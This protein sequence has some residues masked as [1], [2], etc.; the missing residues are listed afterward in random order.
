MKLRFAS[1]KD[2]NGIQRLCKAASGEDDYL[3]H[4]FKEWFKPRQI[5]VAEEGGKVIGMVKGKPLIDGSIWLGAARVHPDHRGKGIAGQLTMRHVE[6]NS[7]RGVEYFRALISQANK[8]SIRSIQKVGFRPALVVTIVTTERD[9]GEKH[10]IRYV[11]LNRMTA[12]LKRETITAEDVRGSRVI[13]EMN[14]LVGMFYEFSTLNGKT[15]DIITKKNK[16]FSFDGDGKFIIATNQSRTWMTVQIVQDHPSLP[17]RLAELTLA[18]GGP[19]T[20]LFLP[21]D[22][23]LISKYRR[24]GFEYAG[25]AKRANVMQLKV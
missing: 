4:I 8:A 3:L 19:G 11:D 24:G 25:W 16:V 20:G 2:A 5:A 6:A 23:G 9:E 12:K 7:R 21:V 13:R 10:R 17:R 1:T 15:G 22:S 18:D 14:G